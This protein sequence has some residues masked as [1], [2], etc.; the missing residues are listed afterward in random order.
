M[1]IAL[2]A[3]RKFPSVSDM[4]AA[5][6]AREAL[7]DCFVD[8]EVGS[9]HSCLGTPAAS[10]QI[11]IGI[12]IAVA[13]TINH[14]LANWSR[15][16]S[17][18]DIPCG[19]CNLDTIGPLLDRMKLSKQK[20]EKTLGILHMLGAIKLR[21][22]VNRKRAQLTCNTIWI[23]YANDLCRGNNLLILFKLHFGPLLLG[24]G[25]LLS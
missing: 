20:L 7:H 13:W 11:G 22:N 6:F 25:A 8:C 14:P 23:T 5:Q 21:P 18:S 4:F 24:Q 19:C 3:R 15:N 10:M 1:L 16:E 12:T 17:K 2:D 9:T